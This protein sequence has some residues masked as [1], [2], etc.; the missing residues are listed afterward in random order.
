[1]STSKKYGT[2][3]G[4][5][6]PPEQAHTIPSGMTDDGIAER[7]A[8]P[9][10]RPSV[11][12]VTRE[13]SFDKQLDRMSRAVFMGDDPFQEVI[14]RQREAD[15]AGGEYNRYRVLSDRVVQKKGLREWE[16][17]VNDKGDPVKVAGMTLS[18]MPTDIALQRDKH[19]EDLGNEALKEALEDQ[20]QNQEELI[21]AAKVAGITALQ[22]DEL[23]TDRGDPSRAASIGFSRQR[24][25]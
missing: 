20:A 18:R 17:V 21:H 3:N 2:I 14:A 19:Y 6:I 8:R 7:N 13:P 24:G 4:K 15:E 11:G 22:P 12:T 9:N 5:P 10:R 25:R 16:P 1:M 23:I